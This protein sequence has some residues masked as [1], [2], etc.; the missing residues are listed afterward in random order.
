MQP[1]EY[2]KNSILRYIKM[3]ASKYPEQV[4]GPEHGLMEFGEFMGVA[5]VRPDWLKFKRSRECYGNS[6]KYLASQ[7][8]TAKP[9]RY[10]EGYAVPRGDWCPPVQHAWLVDADGEVLDPTWKDS[11]DHVYFGLVFQTLFAFEMLEKACMIPGILANPLLMRLHFGS[12]NL[13]KR[14]IDIRKGAGGSKKRFR[15]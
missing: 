9:L 5:A 3:I 13:L 15:S 10:A 11:S 7:P 6:L 12:S 14:S 2:E 8:L 1:D 4:Y